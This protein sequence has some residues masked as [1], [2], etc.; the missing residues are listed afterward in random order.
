MRFM[1]VIYTV[2]RSISTLW[3]VSKNIFGGL[4]CILGFTLNVKRWPTDLAIH[5]SSPARGRDLFN[6][7]RG[8]IANTHSEL[9]DIILLQTAFII[10]QPTKYCEERTLSSTNSI[11]DLIFT[12]L[13]CFDGFLFRWIFLTIKLM[14][15]FI[16]TR[17]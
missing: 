15:L 16:L 11:S 17:L 2:F 14:H 4:P 10:I 3:Y 12:F 7:K 9:I 13:K 6:R 8:S 5:G 1:K